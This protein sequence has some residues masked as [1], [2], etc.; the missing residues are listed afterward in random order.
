VSSTPSHVVLSPSSNNSNLNLL[1]FSKVGLSTLS[2]ST[3]FKKIQYFSKVSPQSL[4]SNSSNL[5]SKY[6][7]LSDL[8][9]KSSATSNA[10]NYGTFRQHNYTT[11]ASNQYKQGLL[12]SNSVSAIL[13]YNY[14]I[15]DN[16]VPSFD[17]Q[18]TSLTAL[19]STS[20]VDLNLVNSIKDSSLAATSSITSLAESPTQQNSIA[21]T[22]DAKSHNNPL[23]Y[24]DSGKNQSSSLS[25]LNS[26]LS[27]LSNDGAPHASDDNLGLSFKFKD[28]KS[29]NMGFLSSE[30]NVRLID[31]I[32][33]T[34]LNP[35]LSANNNNLEDIVSNSIGDSI[36]PNN[37]NI[38]SMSSND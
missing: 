13:S 25:T 26:D 23:K 17:G 7:K 16:Q 3:A 28:N 22:V 30:K 37:Y 18:N 15:E 14:G 5:E 4:Y 33:P 2:D 6:A 29:P 34:K 31:N 38:Y 24:I 9:L 27:S 1:D 12:D 10:Y 21:S 36:V 20:S 32:N 8:Y 11:S 35:S 19:N